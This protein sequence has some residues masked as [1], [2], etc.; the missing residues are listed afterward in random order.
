M[1]FLYF[2]AHSNEYHSKSRIVLAYI[3]NDFYLALQLAKSIDGSY[4]ESA[5]LITSMAIKWIPPLPHSA[6]R[7]NATSKTKLWAA[8]RT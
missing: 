5:K 2:T 3:N 4:G 1:S 8:S 7:Q 6:H